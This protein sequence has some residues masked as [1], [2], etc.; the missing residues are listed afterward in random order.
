MHESSPRILVFAYSNVGHDCL[1]L[2]LRRH[3]RP[4][5]VFTHQDDP[6]ESR[7]FRSVAE[8]AEAAD[9]PVLTPD[10]LPPAE[11]LSR[12]TNEFR[13]D[14]IFSFYY[15]R[16]IPT[17]LLDTARLGALNIHGSLLPKY[18]GKAPVNW[19][20]LHGETETGA[21]LHHMVREPDAG[22]IVD[23]QAVPIGPRDPAI[24]VMHAVTKAAVTVLDRQIDAL[25]TG[26]APRRPQN[27]EEATYFSGRRPEDGRIDWDQPTANIF[28]L[29]RAVTRPYPG[30]FSEL[31]GLGRIRIWWAEPTN[32]CGEPGQI[33]SWN[34]TIVATRDGS[35]RL[36]DVEP[37]ASP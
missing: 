3:L 36:T 7:W 11:W 35:L 8:R 10:R 32:L 5:A 20:V 37:L 2:L 18:R 31:P 1:D 27:P 24:E 15:R 14:L 29:I 16:M 28:N 25:L 34:P 30:A 17:A 23:Q 4:V 13:P 19:A 21:T 9:L 33:L 22:D 12:F 6:T 26:T